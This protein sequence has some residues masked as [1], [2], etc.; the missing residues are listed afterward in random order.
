MC[1]LVDD[2]HEMVTVMRKL[3]AD[4]IVFKV[5]M[6]GD[7]WVETTLADPSEPN[8]SITGHSARFVSWSGKLDKSL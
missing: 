6:K 7:E 1:H 8:E 2:E 5:T 4:E 3:I